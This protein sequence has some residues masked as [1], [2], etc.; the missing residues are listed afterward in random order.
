MYQQI[1]QLAD[2]ALALQNKDR[3]DAALRQISAM[4]D[5]AAEQQPEQPNDEQDAEQ[6]ADNSADTSEGDAQ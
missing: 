1:K 3:M 5:M 4:C 2:D 6:P